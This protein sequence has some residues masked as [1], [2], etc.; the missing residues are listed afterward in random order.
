[1]KENYLC[2]WVDMIKYKKNNDQLKFFQKMFG[3]SLINI[4]LEND[5]KT[6]SDPF[7]VVGDW[8]EVDELIV[9]EFDSGNVIRISPAFSSS[10]CTGVCFE[11]LSR[12][13]FST[14]IE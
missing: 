14:L 7:F 5:S 8:C 10:E 11:M 12:E 13:D 4:Y 1:M 3:K 2:V 6:Y 9:L